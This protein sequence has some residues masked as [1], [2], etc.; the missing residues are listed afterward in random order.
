MALFVC[1]IGSADGNIL[2]R[3]FEA[4]NLETLRETL[5][6]QGFHVFEIRRKS[7]QFIWKRGGSRRRVDNKELL[8]FNQEL[9]VLIKSGL[10]IV[11]VNVNVQG[12]R[13]SRGA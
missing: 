9:L 11:Q 5:S 13:V 1:K 6:E 3:E 12:V 2:E 4:L 8:T 7:F 10:P